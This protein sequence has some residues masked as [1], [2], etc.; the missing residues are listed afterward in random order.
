MTHPTSGHQTVDVVLKHYF[1]PGREDFRRA[2]ESAMPKLLMQPSEAGSPA[3]GEAGVLRSPKVE[4]LEIC[5]RMSARTW[6]KD[7]E[8]IATLVAGM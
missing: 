5:A 1:R 6:K 2:I 3:A 8:R 7:S 4:I